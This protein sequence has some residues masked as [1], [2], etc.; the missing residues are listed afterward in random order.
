MRL[1]A[2]Q[3]QTSPKKIFEIFLANI[4]KF[5]EGIKNK[6]V[7]DMTQDMIIQKTEPQR[8]YSLDDLILLPQASSASYDFYSNGLCSLDSPDYEHMRQNSIYK[9]R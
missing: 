8:R 5:M 1:E 9:M 3:S 6:L 7:Q 4:K 2:A